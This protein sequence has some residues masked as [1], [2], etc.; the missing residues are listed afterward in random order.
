LIPGS[1][2]FLSCLLAA[3][4]DS[5]TAPNGNV[6]SGV[7]GGNAIQLTV[8]GNGATL[9][10]DCD[11]GRIDQPLVADRG[12]Q[13]SSDGTYSFGHGGPRQPGEPNAKI[14]TARYSGTVTG[15]TMRL[16]VFLPELSRSI[17]DF[18]LQLGRSNL[19]KCL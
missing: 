4:G 9:E 19:E 10:H 13:F 11:S 6:S 17:G 1:L 15:S 16:S 18:T 12:G 7:W 2:V 8:T 14:Y 3:C 5:V